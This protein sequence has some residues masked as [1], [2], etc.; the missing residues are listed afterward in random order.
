MNSNPQPLAPPSSVRRCRHHLHQHNNTFISS[1]H[2]WCPVDVSL[3]ETLLALTHI[4]NNQRNNN[5]KQHAKFARED[6]P[7][8][9]CTTAHMHVPCK[10]IN[11][12]YLCWPKSVQSTTN[13]TTPCRRDATIPTTQQRTLVIIDQCQWPL[14][15]NINNTLTTTS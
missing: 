7:N 12:N 5:M 1:Y 11:A 4:T 15:A 14:L 2:S 3:G 6:G 8:L 9:F 13:D 10:A